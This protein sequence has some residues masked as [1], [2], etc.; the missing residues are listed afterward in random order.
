MLTPGNK[1]LGAHLIWGFGLPS[2]RV[3]VCVAMTP[4]C[5]RVCYAART[6]QYR[7]R[8]ARQYERNFQLTKRKDFVR[9]VR[10][11]LIAHHVRV[12]RIHTG[13]E[14]VS[15]RY[16]QKWLKIIRRSPRVRFFTYTR[17]WSIPAIH[18]VLAAMAALPNCQVWFSLDRDTGRPVAIPL[19][20]RLAWLMVTPQDRPTI[21][22]DL[23]FR[24][25]A[26]RRQPL[27]QLE[28]TT[29]CPAESGIQSETPVT[30]D[31]CRLCWRA[32][33]SKPGR[34]PLKLAP[35]Q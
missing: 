15:A 7:V 30:C 27:V 5:R 26:L 31:H 13:G 20:V 18:E 9:R 21:P 24:V 22:V 34:I 33:A 35:S 16:A 8:A 17:S 28:G 6:E 29:V 11:F 19:N 12:V 25:Q 14:F 32:P 3:D 1:K 2:G 10:A 23:I 4:T